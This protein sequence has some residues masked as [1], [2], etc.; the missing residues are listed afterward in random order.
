MN[1]NDF[2]NHFDAYV[3]EQLDAATR[4]SMRVHMAAC[5]TCEKDVA[6]YQ[7]SRCLLETAVA[8]LASAVDVSA[9][10]QSVE[11]Q[12]GDILPAKAPSAQ[13]LPVAP[14]WSERLAG[15]LESLAPAFSI[16][17]GVLAGSAAAV[18]IAVLSVMGAPS[19]LGGP[20]SLQVASMTSAAAV[21]AL[22]AKT[23]ADDKGA[24]VRTA[25]LPIPLRPNQG[26]PVRLLAAV[27]TTSPEVRVE[28]ISTIPGHA[29]STWVQPRTGARVIWVSDRDQPQAAAVTTASYHR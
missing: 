10:W 3:D 2:D 5:Q 6:R 14:S 12:L 18:T 23:V 26:P 19:H 7:Q 20:E 15:V 21:G 29:V 24:Q 8:E 22:R 27:P 13:R 4:D 9:L 28:R 11:Q 17:G 25:A 16:R 1:C